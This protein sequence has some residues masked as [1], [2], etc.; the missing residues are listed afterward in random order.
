MPEE[1]RHVLLSFLVIIA[2]FILYLLDKHEKNIEE[3]SSKQFVY[4][5]R[6]VFYAFVFTYM[7]SL[8]SS[9]GSMLMIFYAFLF[10]LP[11]IFN[12]LFY[13]HEKN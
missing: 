3:K 7:G 5:F 1:I 6:F 10:L 9:A 8:G 13:L 12:F 4:L 2:I 11:A